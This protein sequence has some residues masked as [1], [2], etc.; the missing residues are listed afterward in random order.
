MSPFAVKCER[1][2]VKICGLT[3]PDE[4]AACAEAGAEA[5]GCVF[6]AKSPRC[7]SPAQ[8]AEIRRVLKGKAALVGV[9]VDAS[10][11]EILA[12]RDRSGIDCAQLH[13][14]EPPA[15][16]ET[17]SAEGM[18]V[19]KTLFANAAPAI[20]DAHR[21]PADAFL[22]ECAGGRLPGGNALAWD[23]SKARDLSARHPLVIAGGLS[24]DNVC[25]AA[26]SSAADAVD[27]SSAVEHRPGRKD[28]DKV[29]AFIDE[30]VRCAADFS[31]TQRRIRRIFS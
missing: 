2:Q 10:A 31:E 13:G 29:A 22:V 9:F 19:I 28:L 5:V 1:P 23:W 14:N 6:F 30:L 27:V 21:Y 7:V 25:Q 15:L 17:L 11:Q 16:V 26:S 18:K 24:Q 4:A 3:R 20:S 12:V 8:A